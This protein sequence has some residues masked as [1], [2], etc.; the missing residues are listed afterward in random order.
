MANWIAGFIMGYLNKENK[1]IEELYLTPKMLVELISK[2]NDG[3]VNIKQVKEVLDKSFIENKDP[4]KLIDE[5]GLS[6][7][8]NEEDIR[9]I[10][11]EVLNDN[12]NLVEDYK[13]GKRV[14]DYI[15]G[16][17][18]KKSKGRVNPKMANIILKEEL[19]KK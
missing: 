12:M 15:V 5:L 19:E 17:I 11:N 1:S 9:N 6:Q 8:T 14:F 13:N 7:I 3:K 18:M 16:Q 10:V 2:L 4:N